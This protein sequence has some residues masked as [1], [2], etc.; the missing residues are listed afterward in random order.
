MENKP[1]TK[2]EKVIAL[3]SAGF[4]PSQIDERLNLAPGTAHDVMVKRWYEDKT[5]RMRVSNATRI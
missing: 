1:A 4:A 3:H 2:T 5:A